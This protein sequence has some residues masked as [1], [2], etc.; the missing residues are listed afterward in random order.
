MDNLTFLKWS[1]AGT[2]SLF[3]LTPDGSASTLH[4][5][6]VAII[7]DRC[8]VLAF[9]FEA[10]AKGLMKSSIEASSYRAAICFLR[11][12]Y[13]GD[14]AWSPDF[15]AHDP[16]LLIHA[17][18]CHLADIFECPELQVAAHMN[19]IGATEVACSLPSPPPD[20]CEAI[21][22]FYQ[23]LSA[24]RP[25]IDT[26]LHYCVSCFTYHKLSE[27]PD[28]RKLADEHTQFH[29]DLSRTNAER[30]FE[31]PQIFQLPGPKRDVEDLGD[32]FYHMWSDTPDE[33]RQERLRGLAHRPK[34]RRTPMPTSETEE[35][36]SEVDGF[37][38]VH[39]PRRGDINDTVAVATS[40]ETSA[41]STE[42]SGPEDEHNLAG[43]YLTIKPNSSQPAGQIPKLE[44]ENA[45]PDGEVF[46]LE[47]DQPAVASS[48]SSQPTDQEPYSSESEWSLVD[49]GDTD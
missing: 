22:F 10:G 11:Y 31:D 17:E 3:I 38:L 35:S 49:V 24:Q 4:G 16:S 27:D 36:A 21:P 39:R 32:F 2:A 45:I 15:L 44:I 13:T 25:L 29:M 34:R 8:P 12:I 19:I 26:I 18:V 6:D 28:F 23:Y 14:Y 40:S 1:P 37:T 33:G 30:N 41:N 42:E 47:L 7:R 46:V 5:L 43:S 9:S 48:S 20:L